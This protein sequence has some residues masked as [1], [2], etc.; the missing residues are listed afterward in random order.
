[1]F[2]IQKLELN[3]YENHASINLYGDAMTPEK[4]RNLADELE[5]EISFCKGLYSRAETEGL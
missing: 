1:M 5:M 2:M 4:L 3:S